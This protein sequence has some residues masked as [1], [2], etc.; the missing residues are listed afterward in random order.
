MKNPELP[1]FDVSRSEFP[2]SSTKA[3]VL[4]MSLLHQQRTERGGSP[5]GKVANL[6]RRSGTAWNGAFAERVVDDHVISDQDVES[7][8]SARS[9]HLHGDHVALGMG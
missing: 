4:S 5:N 9:R 3:Y 1:P 8:L 7:F 2:D 6:V